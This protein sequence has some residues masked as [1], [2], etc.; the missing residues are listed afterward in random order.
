MA[1]QQS[2][3]FDKYYVT[4]INGIPRAC[5]K[6][7]DENG[8]VRR[9]RHTLDV[10]KDAND[11]ELRAA[12]IAFA[13]KREAQIVRASAVTVSVILGLYAKDRERDGKVIENIKSDIR[14]IEPFFGAMA[15]QDITPDVCRA[16]TKEEADKGRA[17][18]T[19]L[20]RLSRLRAAL[21]WAIPN[22]FMHKDDMPAMWFPQPSAPRDRVLTDNE[23]VALLDELDNEHTQHVRLFV[24]LCLLTGGR[25]SAV[26]ELTW[27]RVDFDNGSI[28]LKVPKVADIMKKTVKKGR[29]RV[30][31]V[32]TLRTELLQ[33]KQN[34]VGKT[35]VEYNGQPIKSVKTALTKALVRAGIA[36]GASAHTLRHTAATWAEEGL[37]NDTHVAKM[38]GHKNVS[39]TR[40]NYTHGETKLTEGPT[41]AVEARMPKSARLKIVK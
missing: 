33:A 24:M 18:S 34:A 41:K 12:L 17:G 28:N 10:R 37:V 9:P 13:T 16:Y 35:V 29:A 1:K 6:E 30:H 15:P 39:T 27:D 21:K 31:M 2:V 11:A 19:V 40:A 23:V 25:T 32:E 4:R 5:W 26:L 38:L 7:K 22:K 20:T 8:D 14:Q 36:D 3:K